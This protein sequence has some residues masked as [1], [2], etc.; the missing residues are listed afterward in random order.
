MLN[1]SL[2]QLDKRLVGAKPSLPLSLL[3]IVGLT[4]F[5]GIRERAHIKPDGNQTCVVSGAAGAC[6]SIAGQVK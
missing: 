5:L 2:L 3:G 4:S 6:G 1:V